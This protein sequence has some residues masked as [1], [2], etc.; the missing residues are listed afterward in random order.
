MGDHLRRDHGKGYLPV[1]FTFRRGSFRS[2][3]WLSYW[4][5][6]WLPFKVGAAPPNSIDA[7]LGTAG[8]PV[9]ALDLRAVPS[10]GPVRSW[11]TEEHPMHDI[12]GA[13]D[14]VDPEFGL[15]LS[16]TSVTEAF[17]VLIHVDQTTPIRFN[18]AHSTLVDLDFHS[19][20]AF[21]SNLDFSSGEPGKAPAG[22][23]ARSYG[24]QLPILPARAEIVTIDGGGRALALSP[25]NDDPEKVP[26]LAQA[27][28]ATPYRGKTLKV[29]AWVKSGTGKGGIEARTWIRVKTPG[30]VGDI[31]VRRKKL[32]A[33]SGWSKVVVEAKVP[34]NAT[35]LAFGVCLIG[36]EPLFIRE[37]KVDKEP[38]EG[39]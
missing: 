16:P 6:E 35:E 15:Y 1:G 9:M 7:A 10:D 28:D 4:N 12:G 5:G 34:R 26:V 32:D 2:K 27:V 11:F 18:A 37:L 20:S 3:N 39:L 29:A 23:L 8:L 13:F 36:N 19:P 25:F 22:W 17:D 14:P 30:G 31:Q 33:H 38:N 24:G 21:A